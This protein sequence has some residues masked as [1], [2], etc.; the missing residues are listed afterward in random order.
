MCEE[1]KYHFLILL[2]SLRFPFVWINVIFQDV[3]SKIE[4]KSAREAVQKFGEDAETLNA[5]G[6]NGFVRGYNLT[7]SYS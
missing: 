4:E 6:T 3:S 2:H 7:F 5:E 1:K